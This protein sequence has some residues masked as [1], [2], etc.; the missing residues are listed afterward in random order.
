MT[1][2]Y[3]DKEYKLHG[4]NL[5]AENVYSESEVKTIRKNKKYLEN[6]N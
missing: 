3:N 5:C 2:T 1:S 4:I 6:M